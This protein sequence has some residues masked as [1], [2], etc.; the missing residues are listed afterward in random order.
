MFKLLAALATVAALLIPGAPY[1]VQEAD[2][3]QPRQVNLTVPETEAATPV[4]TLLTS[5]EAEAAALEHAGLTADAVKGLHSHYDGDDRIPHWDVE[6][7]HADY[8]YDYEVDASGSILEWS[9]EYKEYRTPAQ[10]PAQTPQPAEPESTTLTPEE[11]K[12]IALKHADL[13][14]DAVTRIKVEL[15]WDDGI[16][17]YDVEFRHGSLEYEY[18]IHAQTGKIRSWDKDYDD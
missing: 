6:F 17:E 13:T 10:K 14:A 1:L 18:E 9:R 5:Q 4:Q 12:A 15:D 8:E 7:F 3:S 2:F 11:V 16:P